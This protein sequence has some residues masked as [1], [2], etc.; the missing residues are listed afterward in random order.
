M[1]YRDARD[2]IAAHSLIPR[3]AS[4][5]LLSCIRNNKKPDLSHLG[6]GISDKQIEKIFE[7]YSNKVSERKKLKSQNDLQTP[8]NIVFYEIIKDK[9]PAFDWSIWKENTNP[10]Q[11]HV[12]LQ[13]PFVEGLRPTL[14]SML[15]ELVNKHSDTELHARYRCVNDLPEE[16]TQP[17]AQLLTKGNLIWP[18][19]HE[20]FQFVEWIRAG[21]NGDQLTVITGL[22]PDYEAKRVGSYFYR[23]TFDALGSGIGVT[24]KRY[25]D[26]LPTVFATFEKIGINVR[27]IAAIG[28]FEAFPEAN[29]KRMK[30]TEEEFI[31]RLLESQRKLQ[32]A[33]PHPIETPLFTDLCGGKSTWLQYYGPIYRRVMSGDYGNS[34]LTDQD[35]LTIAMSRRQLYNRWYGE[36]DTDEDYVNLLKAQAAEYATMGH[37]ISRH[38]KNTLVLGAD[39]ARMS[40][41]YQLDGALPVLYLR[42]N[43]LG[44]R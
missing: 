24:S 17:L 7:L 40:P 22:C 23:Y 10:E 29:L 37:I 20:F 13:A 35:M 14:A 25:L 41:F 2:I 6:N 3:K 19:E 43:Y 32:R 4:K 1:H 36:M 18:R 33:S 16:I 26:A 42:N 34:G 44:V 11:T 38:L 9:Y 28:D 31:S 21:I 8:R 5:Y 27:Y 12:R 15:L 30:L 39:H